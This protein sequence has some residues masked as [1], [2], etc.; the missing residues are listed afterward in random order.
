VLTTPG[1][2]LAVASG[3]TTA[4]AAPA[5][6]A[7]HDA[8]GRDAVL[9]SPP[10]LL[11]VLGTLALLVAVVIGTGQ[12]AGRVQQAALGAA[13]LGTS[14][15]VVLEYDTDVP[16]FAEWLYLPVLLVAG[17]ASM[18]VVRSMMPARFTVPASVLAYFGLRLAILLALAIPG[19]VV[20]DPP[21]A[22]LGLLILDLPSRWGNARW[23]LA[24]LA[25]SALQ[26]GASAAGLSSVRFA[27]TLTAAAVVVPLLL[28][29]LLAVL[30]RRG[31]RPVGVVAGLLFTLA[32]L[33]PPQARAHDPGQGQ[34]IA[35]VQITAN[36]DHDSWVIRLDD[37][38]E[39]SPADLTPIR[40]L[41]RRAGDTVTAPLAGTGTG[42]TGTITLPSPGRWFVY[43]ELRTDDRVAETWL[44]VRQD[45]TASITERRSLY[46]PAGT[47]RRPASEYVAGAGLLAIG[48]MLIGWTTLAVRRV[49]NGHAPVG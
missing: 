30:P 12:G 7:W 9:W 33:T 41:A 36:R 27:S 11:S 37:V 23:P 46:L 40:L 8:F 44:P 24:G 48:A 39:T 6:A 43:A 4:A 22:L 28:L 1:L 29:T 21:I 32:L 26:L 2:A 38:K 14:Q 35:T 10:H 13:L 45:D 15:I 31:A 25:V 3:I 20:P 34:N 49:R 19:W 5:D 17:L 16:Q 18:W 47:A 42:F